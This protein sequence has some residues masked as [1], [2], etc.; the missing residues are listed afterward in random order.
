VSATDSPIPSEGAAKHRSSESLVQDVVAHGN[1][2][3]RADGV[4]SE[5]RPKL[6]PVMDIVAEVVFA[7]LISCTF[8]PTGAS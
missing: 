5:E 2:P 8:E 3:S 7:V 4:K 1:D 6:T